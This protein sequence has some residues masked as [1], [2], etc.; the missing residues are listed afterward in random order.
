[1][2]ND[3]LAARLAAVEDRLAL[4]EL[5]GMYARTYDARQGE[6]WAALFTHDGIY[7]ARG[8]SAAGGNG[9]F[10]QGRAA[11]ARFCREAPFDGIHFLHLPQLTITGNRA[12]GRVHLEFVAREHGEDQAQRRMAGFYDIDYARVDGRWLIRHRV[13]TSFVRQNQSTFGYPVQSGLPAR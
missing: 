8:A 7:Q 13:T 10:V 4:I 11:L 6:D 3:D 12:L 9:T 1:M 5:E 2:N